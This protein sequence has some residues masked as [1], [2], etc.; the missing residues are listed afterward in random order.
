M[1]GVRPIHLLALV[2][3][4]AVMLLPLGF[5]V[6]TSLKPLGEV[7]GDNPTLLPQQVTTDNY[8][9]AFT[10]FPF[11]K[12]LSNTLLITAC[13]VTGVLTT[14]TLV[15]WGFARYKGRWNGILFL[16]CL[17]TM[18]LPAQ[19]TAIPV[20]CMFLKLG[21][22]NTYWPLI[23][24]AWLGTHAF[25][26]FLLKQFFEAIPED[27]IDAARVDGCSELQI[28]LKIGVPLSK[29]ILWTIAVFT[30][31]HSWNDYFGPLIYLTD[32]KLYP[33]SLGLTYFMQASHDVSYG[34]QW[35]LMMA[36]SMVT[37]IPVAILFFFAQRSFIDN[38]L[39]G[40]L[41]I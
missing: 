12:Y 39:A 29:P 6:A 9:K 18:M 40:G 36:V 1:K 8:R 37:M 30:F 31:I 16:F 25:F 10:T 28:L 5:M 24:P 22:Y 7:L 4:G 34:T 17:S 19:V 38:A 41:K 21:M 15:A 3:I 32:E 14:S 35:N 33:L 11:V 13:R 26:I 23:L 20:F 2:A 27:L